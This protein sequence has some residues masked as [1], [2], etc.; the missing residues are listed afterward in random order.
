M[1][2][3]NNRKKGYQR[4]T[5]EQLDCYVAFLE[6]HPELLQHKICSANPQQTTK[7]WEE[8][9]TILNSKTGPVRNTQKWKE[10]LNHW[11]HQLKSRARKTKTCIRSARNFNIM[12]TFEE[13]ALAVF[14]TIA[15]DEL[16]S[17][18]SIGVEIPIEYDLDVM[19]INDP[20]NTT[21]EMYNTKT[22]INDIKQEINTSTPEINNT[23]QEISNTTSE[24]N[25]TAV[26][27]SN[28]KQ[29]PYNTILETHNTASQ[30]DDK[31][32]GNNNKRGVYNAI[33][34]LL[35][36]FK[37]RDERERKFWEE[38][39]KVQQELVEAIKDLTKVLDKSN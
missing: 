31:F 21:Q 14:G 28:I 27:I 33:N 36:V 9:T 25:N 7:L 23:T 18:S 29:E 17:V 30:T 34:S 10:S 12:T 16:S 11:K 4:C 8:L 20:L 2:Q 1:E 22:E 3:F 15:A 5:Q 35:T 6:K 19:D 38:H 13:R 26:E 24:I 37:E 32:N 39:L